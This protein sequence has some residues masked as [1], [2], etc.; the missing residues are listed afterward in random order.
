MLKLNKITKIYSSGAERVEALKGVSLEFRKSEFVSILGQSGCGKTTLLNI[1]GGLD[2]YTEGDLV[3]NEKSTKTY[4][5]AD[6]DT[7]RNHS[8][9]FVFQSYNLIPHQSV[10][11]NVELALTL[12]GVSKAERRQRAIDALESVGLADQINKKPTQMSGGQMQRVAIARALVNNPDILLADEPTGALDTKTS[13]QIMEILKEVAKDRLVIMV[14]HNPDLAEEYST[15]IVKLSDGLVISDSNPYDSS[16]ETVEQSAPVQSP[17]KQKKNKKAEKKTKMSFFTALSLSMNNL[18]TKKG[19]TVMTS[20]AGS[21]GIIGIA[22]I[23]SL[24]NGIQLFI[25]QVQ[26]DTLSTYPLS[27]QKET[28]DLGA[29][30]S[31]MTSVEGD[32]SEKDPDKIYVDD[33]MGNM[34]NAMLSTTKNDLDAFKAYI[35]ANR[36]KIDP[37]INDIQYTYALDLQVFNI[38]PDV[39]DN[40]DGYNRVTK[41]GLGTM[42]DS[43]GD[44]FAGFSTLASSSGMMDVMTEMI[45]NQDLLNQQYDVI[46][47]SWPKN[48]NE[49]VL[50]VSK[51]NRVSRMTLYMLGILDQG[52]LEGIMAD[53]MSGKEYVG[54]EVEPFDFDYFLNSEF[55]LV[56]TSEFYFETD[57]TYRTEDGKEY[58]IWNDVRNQ[59]DYNE[60]EFITENG[61]KLKISGIIRPREDATASSISSP[62][63]YTKMLTDLVLENNASSKILNQQKATPEYNVTNGRPHDLEDKEYTVENIDELFATLDANT[64]SNISAWMGSMLSKTIMD[65]TATPEEKLQ[66][67]IGFSTLLNNDDKQFIAGKMFD[68]ASEVAPTN[69]PMIYMA[70]NQS[71][72]MNIDSREDL[73]FCLPSIAQDQQQYMT[74]MGILTNFCADN[75]DEYY[76]DMS[77][78]LLRISISKEFCVDYIRNLAKQETAEDQAG[79]I[80]MSTKQIIDMLKKMAPESDATYASTLK[81]LGD[82]EKASPAS[83]NFYA[84]DFNSKASIEEFIKAYN[85]GLSED[86]SDKKIEY[87]DIIGTMMSSVSTIIDVISYVLIAFVAISLVVSSIM[88]GIITN[89]SVL[90]RTKEIGIL[91]A[92]GASK[93]DVSRVFNAET[94]II[95]T[96][97]GVLGIVIT[98][99][100]CLPTNAIIQ[101]LTGFK[102]VKA[103]LPPLAAVI[104]IAISM[105]LTMFAGLI[106]SRSAAKKDPVEALRSE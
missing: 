57:Q 93:K 22:L 85:D 13:V 92:I 39:D 84:K 15:R 100:L 98:L 37:Y 63:A 35:D 38:V 91:R 18:F 28:S 68:H 82:A 34:V 64:M 16:K 99:L 12:S 23:L 90:E 81:K 17:K 24:S 86:E 5:D 77:V 60:E 58:P 7:Y 2:R 73:M 56:N 67:F 66:S 61:L 6:W 78:M 52:D 8:I 71:G 79:E 102:N 14:T 55:Y 3:I 9:G 72:V 83:I 69:I 51:D 11:S 10:L 50:V 96:C 46:A 29:M 45:N 75:M 104:L 87:T 88:I 105:L 20:F 59:A 42:L 21:I 95:G 32:D 36:D 80:G 49:V 4:K 31:A 70:L 40:G 33:S 65:S 44:S 1:I 76:A 25:N 27:I 19:R 48:A 89:I 97:A 54:E 41:L 30:M 94:F 47:G 53:I 101:A 43:M 62:I 103:V 74:L 26:E 106:P